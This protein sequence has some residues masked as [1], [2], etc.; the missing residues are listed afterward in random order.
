[1]PDCSAR[2]IS[3]VIRPPTSALPHGFTLLELMIVVAVI[4]ILAML[5][6]P[7]MQDKL[8]RDQ[9]VEA[10]KLADVAKPRVAQAWST[11]RTLPADNTAAGLPVADKIVGQLVSSVEVEGGALHVT[12]GN[13]A[14]PLILGKRLTLRPAVVVDEPVVPVSWVC[15]G[16]KVPDKMTAQGTDRTDVPKKYLPLNCR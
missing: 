4:A 15:A 7:N 11:T 8:V 13:S 10:V 3:R 16:G 6:L 14:N 12:F 9:I 2:Y 1:V 5:A